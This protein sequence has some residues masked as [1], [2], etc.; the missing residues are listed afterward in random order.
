MFFGVFE[1]SSARYE[2]LKDDEEQET[3]KRVEVTEDIEDVPCALCGEPLGE[4]GETALLK[5]SS[6]IPGEHEYI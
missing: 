5:S 3:Y 2:K 1:V 6:T 4:Q